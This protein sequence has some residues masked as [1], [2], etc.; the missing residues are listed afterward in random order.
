[1]K[2]CLQCGKPITTGDPRK[3]FCNNSC[4]A[5]YSNKQRGKVYHCLNCGNEM[6]YRW[7]SK[8]CSNSCQQKYQQEQQ[9]KLWKEGKESGVSAD[10]TKRFIK[11]YMI[12]KHGEKCMECGWNKR[13][14][15]TGIIPIQ[16]EHKDGNY[17]NNKEENL[18]LLCPNCHSLTPTFG[19][20][21][22]GNG[23]RRKK[24]PKN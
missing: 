22:N 13:H 20:L 15:I 11:R 18:K 16:L 1:M 12:K 3:K 7:R 17:T 4:S 2:E 23:R 6:Q 8:Y 21:N 14:P 19:G 10:H 9:V 24:M 5:S